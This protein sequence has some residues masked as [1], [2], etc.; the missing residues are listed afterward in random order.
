M[1]PHIQNQTARSWWLALRVS[2]LL[3]LSLL[4]RGGSVCR[5]TAGRKLEWAGWKRAHGPDETGRWCF[6]QSHRREGQ[7]HVTAGEVGETKKGN[8]R[9]MF[10]SALFFLLPTF[11]SCLGPSIL[12]VGF[13]GHQE[14]RWLGVSSLHRCRNSPSILCKSPVDRWGGWGRGKW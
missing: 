12:T 11:P 7:V 14:G 5:P 3:C 1:S 6:S 8:N 4:V 13:A 2:L 10:L 9:D